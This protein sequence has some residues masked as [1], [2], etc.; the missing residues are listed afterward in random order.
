LDVET[1]EKIKNR[2]EKAYALFGDRIKYA[3]PDCGLGS[4][5]SQEL[6]FK[7]LQNTGMG[8]KEFLMNRV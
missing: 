8:I 7:L 2:L 6:A 3:G 4:W 1:K 5:P